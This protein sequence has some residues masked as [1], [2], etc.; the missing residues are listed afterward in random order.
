MRLHN[1]ID[2]GI[3][4]Q[5][6]Q[7][8]KPFKDVTVIMSTETSSSISLIRPLLHQLIENVK[9]TPDVDPTIIHQ[10]KAAIYH[11]LETR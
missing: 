4:E 6:C 10:M 8:L 2:V 11:D 3:M 9:P 5:L 1:S 7:L